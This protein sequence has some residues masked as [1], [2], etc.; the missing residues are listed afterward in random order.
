MYHLLRG[1]R[2]GSYV[3]GRR[4]MVIGMQKWSLNAFGIVLLRGL[5]KDTL[6]KDL[7]KVMEW[8]YV[9]GQS[10]N[11]SESPQES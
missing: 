5:Q 11:G 7:K 6:L 8:E 10:M 9:L 1:E 2:M 4:E 3:G